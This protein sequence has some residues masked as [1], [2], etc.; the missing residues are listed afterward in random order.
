MEGLDRNDKR[1]GHAESNP[2]TLTHAPVLAS[3]GTSVSAEWPLHCRTQK[4]RRAAL[5]TAWPCTVAAPVSPDLVG[6]DSRWGPLP[7][8]HTLPQGRK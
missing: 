3:V 2:P 7:Q 5:T 8:L 6:V 4:A 1:E